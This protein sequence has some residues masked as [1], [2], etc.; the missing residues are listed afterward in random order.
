MKNVILSILA[1]A[2]VMFSANA[3]TK[4]VQTKFSIDKIVTDYLALKNA[5]IKD[6]SKASAKAGKT[7]YATFNAVKTNTIDPKLKKSYLDIA[8]SAK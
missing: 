7:L 1:I 2:L 5:L 4:K 8:E 3:Q 6:D